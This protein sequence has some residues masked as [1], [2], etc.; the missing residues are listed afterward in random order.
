MPDDRPT[1]QLP[2]TASVKAASARLAGM[3]SRFKSASP[4]PAVSRESSYLEQTGRREL[5]P[6]QARRAAKKQRKA[7]GA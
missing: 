3:R 1:Y 6:A 4:M 7:V 2:Q 5:T